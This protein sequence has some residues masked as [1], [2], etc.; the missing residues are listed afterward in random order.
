MIVIPAI[1]LLGQKAVRLK[2][3]DYDLVTSYSDDPIKLAIQ[4]EQHGFSHLHLV[5]LEGARSGKV[6]ELRL[7]KEIIKA[8]KLKVDFGGGIK[9]QEDLENVFEAGATQVN[10]GSLAIQDPELVGGWM[11]NYGPD[12][13]ILSADVRQEMVYISG[14]TSSSGK[15]LD[16]VISALI[17]FGLKTITCTDITRDGMMTGPSIDLYKR[18]HTKFFNLNIIASGGVSAVEDLIRLKESGCFAAIAGKSILEGNV[19]AEEI[20]NSKLSL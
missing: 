13:F 14:W 8:T 3:G 19:T 17:P 10:I 5:D 16:E 7:L 6:I 11:K 9:S 2:Q 12:R 4:F 15:P 20:I 1:D 18:L